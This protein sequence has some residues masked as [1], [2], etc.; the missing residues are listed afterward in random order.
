VAIKTVAEMVADALVL[1]RETQSVE[2]HHASGR[3]EAESSHD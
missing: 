3:Q 1:D 2:E